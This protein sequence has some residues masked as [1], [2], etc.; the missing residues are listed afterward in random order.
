ELNTNTD[1]FATMVENRFD[2]LQKQ[3]E[4]NDEAITSLKETVD[5]LIEALRDLEIIPAPFNAGK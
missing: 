2:L 5:M 4:A 3:V 1:A